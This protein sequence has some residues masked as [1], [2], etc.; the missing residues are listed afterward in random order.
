MAVIAYLDDHD[1]S[2]RN[3]KPVHHSLAVHAEERAHEQAAKDAAR[4]NPNI[5]NGF[6]AALSCYP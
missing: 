2:N 3:A 5:D 6:S 1:A 4:P